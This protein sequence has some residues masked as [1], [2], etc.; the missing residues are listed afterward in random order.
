M[1]RF[2]DKDS[3]IAEITMIGANGTEWQD[4]FY[5][6]GGLDWDDELEA[7]KVDDIDYL[8]E[9]AEDWKTGTGDFADAGAA[10]GEYYTFEEVKLPWSWWLIETR[11]D[12]YEQRLDGIDSKEAAV[13]EARYEYEHRLTSGERKKVT[14][15]YVTYAPIHPDCRDNG[16]YSSYPYEGAATE[17]A[18]II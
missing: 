16:M 15:L 9:Q 17:I 10:E 4:D 1:T 5:E 8:K 14:S 3:R 11:G 6:V 7:Y 18:T 2:V 13:E 12:Q